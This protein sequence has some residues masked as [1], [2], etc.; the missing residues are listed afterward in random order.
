MPILLS[1]NYIHPSGRRN[2]RSGARFL[3]KRARLTPLKERRA[4]IEAQPNLSDCWRCSCWTFRSLL[5][6]VGTGSSETRH[7]EAWSIRSSAAAK[8]HSCTAHR[9]KTDEQEG[10]TG[11]GSVVAPKPSAS[12]PTPGHPGY[13]LLLQTLQVRP[14]VIHV[15][16]TGH[17]RKE[18][19]SISMAGRGGPSSRDFREDSEYKNSSF[20]P[21]TTCVRPIWK[22]TAGD[23]S[24]PVL[25]NA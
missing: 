23:T 19:I 18:G 14:V 6:T 17:L 5:R 25:S 24:S 11:I 13:A 1:D 9:R 12:K 15:A 16:F 21:A 8:K 20:T 7:D 2:C 3:V 4:M 22:R 10:S